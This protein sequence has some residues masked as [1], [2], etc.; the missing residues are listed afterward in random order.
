M[1][2]EIKDKSESHVYMQSP[3]SRRTWSKE[4]F[5]YVDQ[6]WPLLVSAISKSHLMA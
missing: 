6:P 5:K 1:R 4:I 2:V 3:R